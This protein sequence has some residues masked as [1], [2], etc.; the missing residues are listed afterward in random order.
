[1]I[2]AVSTRPRA[3]LRLPRLFYFRFLPRLTAI[4]MAVVLLPPSA[5]AELYRW[6]DNQGRVHFGDRPPDKQKAQNLRINP[7]PAPSF[8]T[9]SDEARR[10]KQ[11][12]LLRAWEEERR[13]REEETAKQ[14][15]EQQ[16]RERNC[17]LAKDRLRTYR[18]AG[19]IYDLDKEGKRRT[20]SDA[21]HRAAIKEMEE[22]VAHWC[23]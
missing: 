20:L 12:R 3:G 10:D 8:P 18:N 13:Q 14:K 19:S 21:E 22:A 15:D 2:K 5:S 23:S 11:Q 17:H 6:V 16:R 4:L 7:Q 1:M 9:P